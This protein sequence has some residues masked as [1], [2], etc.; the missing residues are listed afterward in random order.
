MSYLNMLPPMG[1]PGQPS[2]PGSPPPPPPGTGGGPP[3]P[4]PLPPVAPPK[5][6]VSL[7]EMIQQNKEKLGRP[8]QWDSASKYCPDLLLKVLKDFN[9]IKNRHYYGQIAITLIFPRKY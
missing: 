7:Q 9:K 2:F 5:Q 4:P 3:P 8:K 1:V 6:P